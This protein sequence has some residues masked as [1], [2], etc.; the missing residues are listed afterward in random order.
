[1][2]EVSDAKRKKIRGTTRGDHT[3]IMQPE[4][5]VGRHLEFHLDRRGVTLEDT[6]ADRRIKKRDGAGPVK[7]LAQHFKPHRR[8]R[9]PTLGK[10]RRKLR[11]VVHY[12]GFFFF[13][14]RYRSEQPEW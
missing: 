2:R 13:F 12:L 9:T 3:K 4:R 5:R 11:Q 14:C 1:M 7:K 6:P 8:S 10:D